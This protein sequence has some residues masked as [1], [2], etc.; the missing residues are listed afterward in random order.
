MQRRPLLLLAAL[1]LSARAQWPAEEGEYRIQQALYGTAERHI[2]VTA[3]LREIARSDQRVRLTNELFGADP[4]R[5]EVKQLRIVARSPGGRSRVFEYTE[6]SLIDG[7]QFSGWSR[8]DWGQ[9]GNNGWGGRPGYQDGGDGEWRILQARYGT[10]TR[11][12]D[13]SDKLRDLARTDRRFRLSNDTFGIDP[14]RGELKALRISARKGDGAVRVF[15]YVEGSWVDGAQFSGWSGGNWGSGGVGPQPGG[16]A[17]EI[18]QADYGSG[19]RNRDV[20]ERLRQRVFN[21][22]LSV[23][24]DNNGMGGD[25]ARGE[26]KRLRL[27]YRFQGREMRREVAEGQALNLP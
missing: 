20:T 12:V 17:L 19:R 4:A 7:A 5:G 24:V 18:L 25:P 27:R 1:P 15:E 2:D 8:G 22:R 14:A 9:G 6:G 3:R 13:V 10:L 23:M 11:S 16:Q 21:G 26:T